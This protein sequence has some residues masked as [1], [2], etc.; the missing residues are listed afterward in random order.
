MSFWGWLIA[1]CIAVFFGAAIAR[2]E[3]ANDP[4][5]PEK[6]MRVECRIGWRDDAGR[7]YCSGMHT[8]LP[9]F[10]DQWK[11]FAHWI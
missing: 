8:L 10:D 9:A 3:L 1:V 5:A 4:Q 7:V 11:G 6:M 2:H